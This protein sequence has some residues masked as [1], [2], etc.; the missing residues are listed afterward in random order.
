MCCFKK[1][2]TFRNCIICVTTNNVL[3]LQDFIKHKLN[4]QKRSMKQWCEAMMSTSRPV[5]MVGLIVLRDML[6]VRFV[7]ATA[8]IYLA[9]AH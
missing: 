1:L 7:L 4:Y 2:E 5:G 9:A 6:D 8:P 3:Y